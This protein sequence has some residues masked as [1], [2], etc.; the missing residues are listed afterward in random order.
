MTNNQ[1]VGL[2]SSFDVLCGNA[3]FSE[4]LARVVQE[5]GVSQRR[6]ACPLKSDPP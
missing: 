6:V 1:K 4:A 2:V 5:H 3:T